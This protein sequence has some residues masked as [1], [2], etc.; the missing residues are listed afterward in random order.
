VNAIFAGI[1]V[2]LAVCT[3]FR[4]QSA[5]LRDIYVPQAIKDISSSYDT[6]V[7]MFGSFKNFLSRLSI[8]IGVPPTPTLTNV[9]VKVIV[10]LLGTLAL[11]TKEVKQGRFSEFVLVCVTLD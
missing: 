10:E 11:V 3:L 9:L 5:D 1:A 8:Y 6:L 2:L 4:S 7:V